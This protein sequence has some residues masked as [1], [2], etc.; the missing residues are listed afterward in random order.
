MKTNN[1]VNSV[2]PSQRVPLKEKLFFGCADVYGGGAQALVA[3]VYLVFLVNNGLP[4]AQAGAIVMIAKIWDAVTDPLMGLIS[5]N[6]RTKWGRRRPYI[7]AGGFLVI[8]SFGLLFLPLYGMQ[9]AGLKFFIYTITYMFYNT[10]S[11]VINVPY[12]SMST[13]ISTDIAEKT[14]VNSIR[15]VFSMVSSAV[16]SLAPIMLVES[17]QKGQMTINN[18]SLIMT[19]VFG[20]FYCIPLVLAAIFTKERAEIPKIK[21]KFDFRV[22]LKPLK[23]KAFVYFLLSYLFAFTCMDLI[24]AN[25]VFFANYGLNLR[26]AGISSSY[27]LIVIMVSYAASV[28]VLYTL[29]SKGWAKPKLF[30]LGIP[31]YI[32]GIVMLCL[33]PATWP[34]W[35]VLGVCVIVGLGLSGCQTIP[36]ILFPDIVDVG[37]LKLGTRIAGS[38]SGIMTFVRK[39]TSAIAILLSSWVLGWE[40]VGFRPPVTN[41]LTGIISEFTQPES[42]IWGLRMII[43]VPVIIF[44]SLAFFFN[45]KIKLDNKTSLKVK[46]FVDMQNRGELDIELMSQE[47]KEMYLKIK[48]ELF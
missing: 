43:M 47:D 9:S 3:A 5:D 30:R 18:F 35:P 26:D 13:E 45:R 39:S 24:T 31:L 48:K 12:S 25:I 15:L 2:D 16:S 23:V 46:E 32:V 40:I 42:A 7:F 33:Y 37:E 27:L 20:V 44:I 6:T 10:V 21:A 17:L 4:I 41:Y 1:T 14:K 19:F 34:A 28:P 38:F 22:F 36:W 11:T 8:L 29:M